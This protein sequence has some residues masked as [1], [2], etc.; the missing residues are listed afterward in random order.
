M[1]IAMESE[2]NR[3][4]FEQCV[5]VVC[6]G[7][8]ALHRRQFEAA[9]QAFGVALILARSL[10]AEDAADMVPLVLFNMSLLQLRQ[11]RSED[12]RKIREGANRQLDESR[13]G[14]RSSLYQHL[15]GSVLTGLGD[16]RRAIPFWERAIALKQDSPI[17][18]GEALWRVGE[19]YGKSGLRD[20]AAIA[21]RAAARIFRSYPEDP[22]LA[23]IL[24]A[25]GNSLRKSAPDEAERCYREA[26]EFHEARAQ[27]ESATTAW[28]NLG[29][30][31]SE[32]ERPEESLAYYQKALRVREQSRGTPPARKGTLQ[33]NI[34]NC[35]RRMGKF[36]EAEGAVSRAIELLEPH[37]GTA[38]AAAYGTRGLIFRDAKRDEEAA[39][40]L[41]KACQEHQKLPSPNLETLAED[42]E[43][44]AGALRRLDRTDEAAA[45][46][47]E[48][49]R[50]RSAMNVNTQAGPE[51]KHLN[52]PEGAVL[53]ELGSG[54]Y[55][56]GESG[57][58][59]AQKLGYHLMELVKE[60]QTGSYGGHVVLPE[61]TVLM[62]YGPDAE[63]LFQVM[64]PTLLA[65]ALC[66]GARVTIRQGAKRREM[67]LPGPV[68]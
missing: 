33:N 46:E 38:L 58:H 64:K 34:A 62:F 16:Y 45:V 52:V 55:S 21:L 44:L 31:C 28:V 3:S 36:G 49:S 68:M 40:W 4:D 23:A 43:N 67:M 35:Y 39:A 32:Q 37:G 14:S 60:E 57:A 1:G 56:A 8:L 26:A 51:L 18:M 5:A 42:L 11:G 13:A 2:A 48:F 10:A 66:Q 30:L 15:M 47:A 41:G 20:H 27:L 17:Q 29:V 53:I 9:Q 19:C 50:V 65:E 24:I 59:G 54:S 61:S 22:R 12:S 63:A 6:Q 7:Y 25:L